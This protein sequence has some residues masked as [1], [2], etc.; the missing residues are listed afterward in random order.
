M[1]L[2]VRPLSKTFGAEIVGNISFDNLSKKNIDFLN[3]N[4][5]KYQLICM[6]GKPLNAV[7]LLKIA[8][9]FGKPH[10]EI[11]RQHWISKA[12]EI[13]LLDSSYKNYEEKPKNPKLNRRNGWH[14][15]HSFT[16]MPPKATILHGHK[17]TSKA[18]HT[19]FCNTKKAYEDLHENKKLFY[20]KLKVVH[21]YDT[22]RA[23]ARAVERTAEE[24][25]E[26]PDVVHPLIRA[27]DDNGSKSIYFNSNRTDRVLGYSRKE[28]D[29]LLDEIHLHTTK[30]KYRYDHKWKIGD[31][32]IWDNRNLIHSVNVNYPI[33]EPRIHLRTIL[34]GKKPFNRTLNF[35]KKKNIIEK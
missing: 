19:R 32:V 8:N 17:V 31:I 13:S 3:Y 29:K 22:I 30:L 11:T 33:G 6:R 35:P 20:N 12:P 15:D 5:I 18:G 7:R 23:P 14:T 2:Q 27:H 28:S 24:K 34:K 9:Y 26:T 16:K 10:K 1:D 25:N 21:S 4:F